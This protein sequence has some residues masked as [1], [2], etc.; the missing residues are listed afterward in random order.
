MI[1]RPRTRTLVKAQLRTLG[2]QTL[3][4]GLGSVA[5][6]AVGLLTLPV[7]ARV[8][9]QAEYGVLELA[10]VTLAAL[11]ILAD[12]GLASAS[13]RSWFD[14]TEEQH[15]ERRVVMSTAIIVSLAASGTICAALVLAREP[16]SEWLFAGQQYTTVVVLLAA[17]LPWLHLKMIP[18]AAALGDGRHLRGHTLA[19]GVVTSLV[20]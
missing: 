5:V 19:V 3:I 6:Q 10:T 7:F 16:V 18:A 4:Y 1:A 9:S 2:K 11:A 8:F 14:Y 12:A 13:Q 20:T 17:A 15:F